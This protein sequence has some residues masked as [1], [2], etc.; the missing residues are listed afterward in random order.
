MS[1]EIQPGTRVIIAND[2]VV[3]G[4]LAFNKGERVTVENVSPNP[5]KPEYNYMVLSPT[6]GQ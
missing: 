6:L 4:Q 5:Q 2:I 3:N 1:E